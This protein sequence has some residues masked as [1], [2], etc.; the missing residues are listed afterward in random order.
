MVV[1]VALGTTVVVVVVLAG[2]VVVG[3]GTVVVELVEMAE[4]GTDVVAGSLVGFGL[5][6]TCAATFA[7]CV[8][9]ALVVVVVTFLFATWAIGLATCF[10]FTDVVV[11]F[12]VLNRV[13]VTPG[14]RAALACTITIGVANAINSSTLSERVIVLTTTWCVRST[15]ATKRRIAVGEALERPLVGCPCKF[16]FMH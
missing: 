11:T 6:S 1:V 12:G 9:A 13:V 16:L 10:N 3:V 4:L 14:E 5:V 8:M 15:A 2:V 7:A